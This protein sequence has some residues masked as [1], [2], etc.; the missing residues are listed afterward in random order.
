MLTTIQ[1]PSLLLYPPNL[2]LLLLAAA[3]VLALIQKK[4]SALTLAAIGLLWV[5]IWSLPISAIYFGGRLENNYRYLAADKAQLTDAIVV[6]GGNTQSNRS[7]WFEPYSRLTAVDRIDRAAE[8]YFEKKA[9]HIIVSGGSLEGPI[10]EAHGMARALRQKGVPEAVIVLENDSRNTYENALFSQKILQQKHWTS[11]AVVT[12]AL[13]MPRA[14]ATF[15]KLGI[16]AI[17][18][19]VAPQIVIP[20]NMRFN[21]WLPHTR[22][23]EASRSII[24]EYF[25]L[26]GYWLRGWI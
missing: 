12:S 11:V 22:S 3:V 2:C 6:L 4:S 19:N 23:L 13:H 21:P 9:P 8:L 26:L 7:N 20:S 17:P 5:L 16:E 25:G 10:S 24:K 15:K 18:S 1:I 14:I